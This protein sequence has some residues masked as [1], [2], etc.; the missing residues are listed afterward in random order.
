MTYNAPV[1]T[2]QEEA[3]TLLIPMRAMGYGRNQKALLS[4]ANSHWG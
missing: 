1:H 3:H 2:E 4:G